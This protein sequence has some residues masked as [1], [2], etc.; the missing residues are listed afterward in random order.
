MGKLQRKLVHVC[1]SGTTNR[2]LTVTMSDILAPLPARVRLRLMVRNLTEQ[3]ILQVNHVLNG[4][5]TYT[6]DTT[7]DGA[8]LRPFTSEG[9]HQDRAEDRA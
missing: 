1:P 9:R 5:D 8:L 2:L 6:F 7:N 4:S 3:A